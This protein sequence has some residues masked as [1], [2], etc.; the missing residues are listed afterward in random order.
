MNLHRGR[1]SQPLNTN[2]LWNKRPSTMFALPANV[3]R[4]LDPQ[5]VW[6]GKDEQDW[7]DFVGQGTFSIQDFHCKFSVFPII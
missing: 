4:D 7:S 6:R 2:P 3:A 1:T 5:L